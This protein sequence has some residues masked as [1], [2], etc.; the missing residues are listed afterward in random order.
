MAVVA[1]GREERAD[2]VVD[3]GVEVAHRLGVVAR[4]EDAAE[5]IL[6]GDDGVGGE[7]E[8]LRHT[9]EPLLRRLAVAWADC[10]GGRLRRSGRR[11]DDAGRQRVGVG[12][13]RGEGLGGAGQRRLRAVGQ[14][15]CMLDRRA[16]RTWSWPWEGP[17]CVGIGPVILT[18]DS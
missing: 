5:A 2:L 17:D 12:G 8:V 13:E 16:R 9:E 7:A 1:L 3:P 14:S 10:R 15:T 4:V 11:V 18:A 6:V